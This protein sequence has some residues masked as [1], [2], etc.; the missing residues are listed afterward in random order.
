M[1]QDFFLGYN[2]D[3][4]KDRFKNIHSKH[5]WPLC[6]QCRKFIPFFNL[7]KKSDD[8]FLDIKCFYCKEKR[9]ENYFQIKTVKLKTYLD[10]IADENKNKEYNSILK[11]KINDKMGN[12][13]IS[14]NKFA[15]C[16][17]Y[18]GWLDLNHYQVH[19]K[20]KFKTKHIICEKEIILHSYCKICKNNAAKFFC[21]NC[22][23]QLCKICYKEHCKNNGCKTNIKNLNFFQDFLN[24]KFKEYSKFIQYKNIIKK[25]EKIEKTIINNF[26]YIIDF[27]LLYNQ[28][29]LITSDQHFPNYWIAMTFMNLNF[30]NEEEIKLTNNLL[31][32]DSCSIN[33]EFRDILIKDKN[34]Q[35]TQILPIN[36]QNKNSFF[37]STLHEKGS[38]S[39]MYFVSYVKDLFETSSIL[40][41]NV[42][43]IIKIDDVLITLSSN[44]KNVYYINEKI[45][46]KNFKNESNDSKFLSNYVN[47][48]FFEALESKI[49]VYEYI[50]S[51]DAPFKLL[52]RFNFDNISS[53]VLGDLN[54][55]NSPNSEKLSSSI[56]K[57][58][59]SINLSFQ[60]QNS[61]N[62]C[63]DLV[64]S[65]IKLIEDPCLQKGK[66]EPYI[67][68]LF[69]GFE[70][71]H[72]KTKKK[73]KDDNLTDYYTIVFQT[74]NI[75]CFLELS[76]HIIIGANSSSNV[77]LFVYSKREKLFNDNEDYSQLDK[78]DSWFSEEGIINMQS[79]TNMI[80][81][82]GSK[83]GLIS[84]W[85]ISSQSLLYKFKNDDI[86]NNLTA[87]CVL[88]PYKYIISGYDKGQIV[89]WSPAD[90]EDLPLLN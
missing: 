78:F 22:E 82:T 29:Y 89:L 28:V 85:N 4:I 34:S 77:N 1:N 12:S 37:I 21:E 14:Q 38:K 15:F 60:K 63:L 19:E 46:S 44:Y 50:Q 24:K 18:H 74:N 90:Y 8:I 45:A 51:I 36:S 41:T 66:I 86:K 35:I 52:Y 10:L 58:N 20:M 69:I 11:E 71:G 65:A 88:L 81:V 84:L 26:I 40:I 57:Q 68:A 59:L 17:D 9:K 31:T 73:F 23:E 42:L 2:F 3:L 30:N 76:N 16:M 49:L 5:Y 6:P 70:N 32:N 13:K 56:F 80:F 83:K 54:S 7:W 72:V 33:Y 53:S 25:N 67:S 75:S 43:S 55:L 47:N 39:S 79:I 61:L 27:F 64:V 48:K 62:E 87:L